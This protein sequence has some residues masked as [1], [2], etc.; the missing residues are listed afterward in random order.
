MLKR[1]I[2]CMFALL[3]F[4]VTHTASAAEITGVRWSLHK[5][6]KMGTL[7]TR[8]VIDLD[9]KVDIKTSFEGNQLKVT[10]NNLTP[11]K[12]SG[13]LPLRNASVQKIAT[14]TSGGATVIAIDLD[15]KI[16][17]GDTNVFVLRKDDA[18]KRPERIV[19]DIIEQR[20]LAVAPAT[21]APAAVGNGK[22]SPPVIKGQTTP[23]TGTSKPVKQVPKNT[24]QTTT[25]PAATNSKLNDMISSIDKEFQLKKITPGIKGKVIVIDAGHGGSDPGAVG[26]GGFKEKEANLAV[27]HKLAAHLKQKGATVHMTRSTD[28]D[29]MGANATDRQDLQFRVNVGTNANA[30]LFISIHSNSSANRTVCGTSV[31]YYKKNNYDALL[32]ETIQ[33]RIVASTNLPDLGTRQAGFYVVKNSK[34][35]A[36]LVEMA[37]ISNE[38]EEKLLASSWFQNK[39]VY[40]IA[41]GIDDFFTA[42][43]KGG[44]K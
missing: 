28:I 26:K 14:T 3:I 11:G 36:V 43:S 33:N 12:H 1:L 24:N 22:I 10:G 19:I 8:I 37:F 6:P 30:D 42:A 4:T 35:P 40:G 16:A 23:T 5:D 34:M 18:N 39:M 27:A 7:G 25:A 9:T 41:A 31:W 29:V 21:T 13:L 2:V 17:Q 38:R 44:G 15:S 32:A 20:G